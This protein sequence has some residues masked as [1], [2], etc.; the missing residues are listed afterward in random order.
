MKLTRSNND[1][2]DTSWLAHLIQMR[3]DANSKPPALTT[4][5][6]SLSLAAME[7]PR[8][9][10]CRAARR[11][12]RLVRLLSQRW[13]VAVEIATTEAAAGAV[14]MTEFA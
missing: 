1:N 12:R 13:V 6:L 11:G 10:Q 5:L 7:G 9:R 4:S 8:L 3:C 2:F 14:D